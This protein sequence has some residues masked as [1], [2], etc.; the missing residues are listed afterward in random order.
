[1]SA[2]GLV[3]AVVAGSAAIGKYQAGAFAAGQWVSLNIPLASFTGLTAKSKLRQLLF[4][5]AGPT[6]LYVDNIYFYKLP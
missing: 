6:V 2:S 5:A 3:T 4:V 1:V